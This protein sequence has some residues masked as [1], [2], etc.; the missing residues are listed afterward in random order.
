[1][2]RTFLRSA[3]LL[4]SAAPG[5]AMAQQAP[6]SCRCADGTVAK[7]SRGGLEPIPKR[8]GELCQGHGG[9]AAKKK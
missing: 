7:G 1:M 8:C 2:I 6:L 9:A 4:M 3:A 5:I